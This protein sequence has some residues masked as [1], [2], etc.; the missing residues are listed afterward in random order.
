MIQGTWVGAHKAYN[1]HLSPFPSIFDFKPEGILNHLIVGSDYNEGLAWSIDNQELSLDTFNFNLIA[2]DNDKLSYQS[3]NLTTMVRLRSPL[4]NRSKSELDDLL[5]NSVWSNTKGDKSFEF[6]DS[7]ATVSRNGNLE[8]RCWD[9]FAYKNY[10]LLFF[11][12][13]KSCEGA[14]G[15]IYQV[16]DFSENRLILLG[17]NELESGRIVLTR[18]KDMPIVDQNSDH[19][20]LCGFY[21]GRS[22][23]SVSDA[24]EMGGRF[25]QNTFSENFQ[26][27]ASWKGITGFLRLKFMVNCEGKTGMLSWQTMDKFYKSMVVPTSLTDHLED[28][29]ELTGN[30]KPLERN[31]YIHDAWKSIIFK[32][33]DGN[34]VSIAP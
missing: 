15:R 19:F 10:L 14:A 21:A 6:S 13:N 17:N 33:E 18:Q 30:W 22:H 3:G 32:I 7:T 12:E 1:G 34:L 4:T 29:F 26:C 11:I 31:D 5:A 9:S 23:L 28:I 25:I 8:I 2:L 20:Q 27:N 16:V 24:H